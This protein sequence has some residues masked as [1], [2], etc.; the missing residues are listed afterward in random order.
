M[1]VEVLLMLVENVIGTADG[2]KARSHGAA[3][4]SA[5]REGK[6]A[7]APHRKRAAWFDPGAAA[8]NSRDLKMDRIYASAAPGSASHSIAQLG[9]GGSRYR[10]D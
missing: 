1:I 3:S 2:G 10:T 5:T 6:P 8:Q 7:A 4:G 9:A